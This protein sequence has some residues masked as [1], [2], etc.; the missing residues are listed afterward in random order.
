MF[1]IALITI[2]LRITI[3]LEQSCV[4]RFRSLVR[5]LDDYEH[6]K[7]RHESTRQNNPKAN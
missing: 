1:T 4:E 7:H 3:Q 2:L 5:F 6:T